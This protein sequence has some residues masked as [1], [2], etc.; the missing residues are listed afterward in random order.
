MTVR[1]NN[2]MRDSMRQTLGGFF[3]GVMTSLFIMVSQIRNRQIRNSQTRDYW[4]FE[5]ESFRVMY[6]HDIFIC[7]ASS[8][9]KSCWKYAA[10]I[11]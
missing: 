7:G 4:I 2:Q 8:L 5:N 1:G 11:Y 3:V 10:E 9:T 6:Y